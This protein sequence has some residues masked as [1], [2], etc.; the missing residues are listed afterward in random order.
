M[1]LKPALAVREA[2]AN[3][4][5]V[6][7]PPRRPTAPHTPPARA[8]TRHRM[9]RHS[10]SPPRQQPASGGGRTPASSKRLVQSSK[11]FVRELVHPVS[12]AAGEGARALHK[13]RWWYDV[14]HTVSSALGAGHGVRPP[15][16]SPAVHP[17]SSA[18][19]CLVNPPRGG[20]LPSP[21]RP[22]PPTSE[23]FSS[24]KKMKF[25]K[26]AG[27]LRP[28][29]GTQAFSWALTPPPSP[30]GRP[31]L[32]VVKQYKSSG[33]SVDTTKTRSGPQR[34]RMCKGEGPMGA[35]KG[36]QTNTMALCQPPPP[37]GL[38]GF[39]FSNSLV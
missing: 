13:G 8:H 34:V 36:K 27:N 19:H 2:A 12:S 22:P 16:P 23:T 10:T 32:G 11:G 3:R 14:T 31:T 1:P 37:G 21:G 6:R 5:S 33:G 24:G 18:G 30:R 39:S 26:V 9:P 28:V 25:I 38:G 7:Q 29:L 15:H 4:I 17:V 20:G 35:A